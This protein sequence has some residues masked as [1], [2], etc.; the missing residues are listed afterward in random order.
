MTLLGF[1]DSYSLLGCCCS[2]GKPSSTVAWDDNE[3]DEISLTLIYKTEI[4]FTN[5]FV[6]SLD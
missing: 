5:S 2:C 4:N 3:E 6:A 1:S